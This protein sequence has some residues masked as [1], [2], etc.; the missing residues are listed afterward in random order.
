[1]YAEYTI[2]LCLDS[3]VSPRSL[4]AARASPHG[5][6]A[7]ISSPRKRNTEETFLISY[8]DI[9]IHRAM[10]IKSKDAFDDFCRSAAEALAGDSNS[11]R[12][13]HFVVALQSGRFV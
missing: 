5:E 10:T 12:T 4:H 7:N 6:S 3:R 9:S 13:N 1:M 2:P 11:D 8:I